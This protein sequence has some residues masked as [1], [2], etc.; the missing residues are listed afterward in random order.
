MPGRFGRLRR[1]F[2]V[3]GT[4][5]APCRRILQCSLQA[6]RAR[7]APSGFTGQKQIG[8]RLTHDIKRCH[9]PDRAAGC[10]G[11]Q[12]S[13][14]WRKDGTCL[15]K[16]IKQRGNID[17][18]ALRILRFFLRPSVHDLTSSNRLTRATSSRPENGFLSVSSAPSNIAISR[19]R[20]SYP[21]MASTLIPGICCRNDLI[22]SRPS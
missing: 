7:C 16:S 10:V 12:D 17:L 8:D 21:D 20:L 2:D 13:Q 22:V 5:L 3:S 19:Y 9:A 6:Y 14:V 18:A 1:A 15:G 11:A 4:W